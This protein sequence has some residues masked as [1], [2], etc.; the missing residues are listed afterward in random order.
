MT[1]SQE[2]GDPRALLGLGD[3]LEQLKGPA[4]GLAHR[5]LR[6]QGGVRI[7]EDDLHA[8]AQI[9]AAVAR[10]ARQ[11]V[12]LE[13]QVAAGSGLEPNHGAAQ[14]GLAAAALSHDG[15][16]APALELDVD[17]VDGVHE[18]LRPARQ[19]LEKAPA[20]RVVALETADVQEIGRAGVG[21]GLGLVA[22]VPFE[23]ERRQR[24]PVQAAHRVLGVVADP[25]AWRHGAAAV[26]GRVLATVGEDASVGQN[27]QARQLP[28]DGVQGAVA[29]G[30][31]EPRD[32]GEQ[33]SGIGVGGGGEHPRYRPFLD[34][35]ARVHHRH[36]VAEPGHHPEVVG[37]VEDGC[38]VP[39]LEAGDQVQDMRLGGHVEPGGGLVHDEQLGVAGEGHGD[40]HP[41]LLAAGELVRVAQR[42][43]RGVGQVDAGQKLAHPVL[44]PLAPEI[45]VLAHH[46]TDL[47]ADPER[48]VERGLRVLVDHGDARPLDGAQLARTEAQ[49][50]DVVEPD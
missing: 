6:I 43:P 25:L 32:A 49:Q 44:G 22:H 4:D 7:L 16:G 23:G 10:E 31:V 3:Q 9:R 41:L 14:R 30:E 39:L 35:L 18:C 46:L 48:R 33:T 15:Q 11:P 42:R 1:L 29:L 40:Q 21:A 47:V 5:L 17:A 19:E 26:V 20:H 12:A 38:S 50:V 28:L 34:H 2:L 13:H 37:D 27:G 45:G 36:S 24:P 8:A